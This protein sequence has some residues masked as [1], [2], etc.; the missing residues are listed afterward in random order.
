MSNDYN[1]RVFSPLQIVLAKESLIDVYYEDQ[2]TMCDSFHLGQMK[3]LLGEMLFIMNHC[4]FSTSTHFVFAGT[5][6]GQHYYAL[7]KLFPSITRM[8]F[9]DPKI[10]NGPPYKQNSDYTGMNKRRGGSDDN[11]GK[12]AFMA[13]QKSGVEPF[14]SAIKVNLFPH[15]LT[16]ETVRKHYNGEKIYFVSDIRALDRREAKRD[17]LNTMAS[18]GFRGEITPEIN[19]MIDGIV[20][21]RLWDSDVKIQRDIL[22]ALNPIAASLKMTIP[23]PQGIMKEVKSVRYFDGYIYLQA[24]GNVKSTESRLIV[25]KSG[26]SWPMRD[27]DLKEYEEKLFYYNT[28]VRTTKAIFD[29]DQAMFVPDNDAPPTMWV[30]HLTKEPL[31]L[32]GGKP[33]GLPNTFD[34]CYMIY[35]LDRYL[36]IYG[37]IYSDL[38][39]EDKLSSILG[40]FDQI[41]LWMNIYEPTAAEPPSFSTR[42]ANAER[43]EVKLAQERI[44]RIERLVDNRVTGRRPVTPVI[45]NS[46][47]LNMGFGIHDDENL[48]AEI[49]EYI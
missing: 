46:L 11:G 41:I 15:L 4:N 18:K 19:D 14:S 13:Y 42:K 32:V 21:K 22:E 33:I 47:L 30:N 8:D 44:S 6:I 1:T 37:S 7:Q 34:T 48:D 39:P 27:Y 43:R 40:L 24:Y 10:A 26:G 16:P 49:G 45:P 3:L 2:N 23:F 17:I 31:P 5:V 28:S 38:G 36:S 20:E 12:N 35:V 9:W 25:T 29:P